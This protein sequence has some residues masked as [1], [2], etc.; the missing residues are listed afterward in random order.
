MKIAEEPNAF[1]CACGICAKTFEPEV[2]EK[3]FNDP[4]VQESLK[5]R[6]YIQ[7]GGALYAVASHFVQHDLAH[8]IE[9]EEGDDVWDFVTAYREKC[10]AVQDFML[11]YKRRPP[12]FR[13]RMKIKW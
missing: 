3:F 8:F 2:D 12:C 5:A 6:E 13:E 1:K 4:R 10:D 9:R 11:H 7:Q